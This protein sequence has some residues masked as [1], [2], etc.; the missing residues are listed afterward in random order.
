MWRTR[1]RWWLFCS[2][3]PSLWLATYSLVAPAR[4][5]E[6]SSVGSSSWRR[7]SDGPLSVQDFR[8]TVPPADDPDRRQAH[9][10][11]TALTRTELRYD[12]VIQT[13]GA[14]NRWTARCR[15]ADA[16]AV[17]LRDRS[18]NLRPHD[19]QL[20]DHEQGHFDITQGL[21]LEV[22]F[23]L[24]ELQARRSMVGT[25]NS[26]TAAQRNLEERLRAEISP[27]MDELPR[28]QQEYDRITGNGTIP[29]AQ[30]DQRRQ[31]LIRI[32]EF[33]EKLDGK[34]GK[35]RKSI[36]TAK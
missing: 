5:A 11:L 23:R 28:A 7:Y 18:W 19:A 35:S 2:L 6:P 4:S 16:Y 21:A 13:S 29:L 12:L 34:K 15:E 20:M 1:W 17:V 33:R 22:Q 30:A 3:A 31:Q 25:G 27:Q 14:G 26:P 24:R 32:A 36:K 9:L 8:G 10:S